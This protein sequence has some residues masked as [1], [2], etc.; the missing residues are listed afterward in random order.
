[1]ERIILPKPIPI[2]K[3][4]SG[5]NT[6]LDPA[7]I[8]FN[9]ET[10][11]S[12]LAACVNCDI[13][14]TGRISRRQGF[15][16]TSRTEAWHSLFSAGSFALGITGNA[17]AVIEPDLSKTNIRNVTQNA[18]MDYVRD[19]DGA[20]DVIYYC[21]SYER[22][23]VINK[24]SFSWD[25][26]TYIGPTTRKTFY[27][28]PTGHLLEIRNL[29]MFIAENK[30]LWYSEPGDYSSYRLAS[31]YFG[32]S[33]RLRMV[34]AVSDGLWVSDSE[35]IYFLKGEII[36]SRLEMPR[37]VKVADYPA[38]EGTAVKVR[39]SRIGEGMPGIVIVFT[40][41]AGICIGSEDGQLINV[42]EKKI[43]LP[44]GL[45]GSGFYKDGKYIVTIN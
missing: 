15:T 35:G 11:I 37:Q 25:V 17:L 44:T 16:A 22:G 14:D 32:F 41:E 10:G 13:D 20:Q 29:R 18:R 30:T 43:D 26:G 8:R 19:T 4:T 5:I 23:K 36:P 21:N 24:I 45:S 3:G 7:R 42:T 28:P 6:K 2:F 38:L 34:Q 12:E 39:G 40:S 31:N 9:P 1:M 33:S 27:S